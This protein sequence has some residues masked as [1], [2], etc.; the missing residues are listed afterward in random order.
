MKILLYCDVHWSET[1]SIIN[2][3][4]STYSTRLE[5]LIKSVSWAEEQADL[6]NCEQI[7]CLGDFFDKPNLTSAE[8]TALN[9]VKW[10]S[11]PHFFLV[12]NHESP[13]KSLVWNSV[14]A[15]KKFGFEIITEPTQ[16][17]YIDCVLSYIPYCLEEDRKPLAEYLP[18]TRK[19]KIVLSHNDIKGI[20][21]G[22][23]TSK[24]GF[25]I[26]EIDRDCNCFLNGHLHNGEKFSKR[27]YNL[28]NLLGQNFTE[29]AFKHSHN[30]FI[31]DTFYLTLTPIENPY[32]FNFYKFDIMSPSDLG[33]F[34]NMLKPNSVL[35]IKCFEPL[36]EDVKKEVSDP[37][38]IASRVITIKETV[39]EAECDIADLNGQDYLTQFSDFTIEKLGRTEIVLAELAEVC[40]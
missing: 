34:N 10:S 4:G 33:V 23:F 16:K 36:L 20:Q 2:S 1:S 28:G 27:G 21:Y 13:R 38:I 30:A 40:K 25:D 11:K 5:H 31:F 9:D 8:L 19:N 32:A 15:L 17:E 22:A 26:E 12:G 18:D 37:S 14:N 6:N 39:S 29:D 24:E 7:I 35:A 3:Q